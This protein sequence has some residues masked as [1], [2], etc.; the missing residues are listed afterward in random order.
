MAIDFTLPKW[1]YEERVNNMMK[2]GST[3]EEAEKIVQTVITTKEGPH[4]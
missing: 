1:R 4:E 3:R 2:K